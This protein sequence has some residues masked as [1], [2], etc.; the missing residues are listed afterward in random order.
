M[1]SSSRTRGDS[2]RSASSSST[3]AGRSTSTS[4]D[5]E[6]LTATLSERPASCQRTTWS[7]DCSSTAVGQV[8]HQAGVLDEREELVRGKQSA[9]RVVP[10]HERLDA[11]HQQRL[12]VDLGLV[13]HREGA[14]VDDAAQLLEGAQPVLPAEHVVLDAVDGLADPVRLRVVH[15]DV[16]LA[17]QRRQLGGRC[18]VMAMPKLA[19]TRTVTPSTMNGG[20]IEARTRWASSIAAASSRSPSSRAN[21]S[22]PRRT[23]RSSPSRRQSLS[24]SAT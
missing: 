10:A 24:R 5:A 19:S 21:S 12:R 2:P 11:G 13:V 8:A 15:R 9:G 20:E 1:I 14:G 23:R 3:R 22:P 6:R 7:S 17:Q 4:E 18:A 16:G